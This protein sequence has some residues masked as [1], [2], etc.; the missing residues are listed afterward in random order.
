MN[1]DALVTQS[2]MNIDEG[3]FN[4]AIDSL[5][6]EEQFTTLNSPLRFT[7]H[8]EQTKIILKAD[9]IDKQKLIPFNPKLVESK[10]ISKINIKLE[11]EIV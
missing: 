2:P 3:Q 7:G 10:S 9:D 8:D 1:V 6:H 11:P 5:K 4:S